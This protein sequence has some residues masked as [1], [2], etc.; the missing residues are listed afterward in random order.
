MIKDE[1][2][3]YGTA[4]G[5]AGQ[6]KLIGIVSR[7]LGLFLLIFTII[8]LVFA[9]LSF[10]SV[11][12]IAIMSDYMPVWAAT[13]IMSSFYVVLI[14]LAFVFRKPLFIHPFIKLLT[15][16]IRSEEELALKMMEADHEVELQRVKIETHI[17]NATRD[18]NFMLTLLGHVWSFFRGK[19]F[20]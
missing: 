13:L 18:L 4:L 16:Q 5:K 12:I 7:V 2:S 11:A 10:C 17:N 1:L 14:G 6:L 3:S 20:K 9:L 15:K 19:I 8:L